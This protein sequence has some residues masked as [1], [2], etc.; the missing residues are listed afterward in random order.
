VRKKD[1]AQVPAITGVSMAMPITAWNGMTSRCENVG[2]GLEGVG[3]N[4]KGEKA[5]PGGS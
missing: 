5:D 2:H 1:K 3:L 4:F